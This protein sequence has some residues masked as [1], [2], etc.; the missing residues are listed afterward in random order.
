[1]CLQS[2]RVVVVIGVVLLTVWSRIRGAEP[3]EPAPPP[4]VVQPKAANP[5]PVTLTAQQDR[6]RCWTC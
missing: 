3:A 4:R 5:P 2:S 1:M 6:Q